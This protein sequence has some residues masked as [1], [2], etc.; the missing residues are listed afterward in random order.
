MSARYPVLIVCTW[1][2]RLAGLLVPRN[3]RA[4]W[5]QDWAAE[6]RHGCADLEHRGYSRSETWSKLLR[7]SIGGFADAADL[8]RSH[9]DLRYILGHPAFCLAVPVALLCIA[10]GSTRGFRHSRQALAGL[11]WH[12]PEELVLLSRSAGVM[13]IEATPAAADF[14][15]WQERFKGGVAG[16]AVDGTVLRVTP[17]FYDVL[18]EVPRVPFDFLGHTIQAVKPLG[19]ESKHI[20]ILAGRSG[21]SCEASTQ[22]IPGDKRERHGDKFPAGART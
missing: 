15:R 5:I 21:R 4:Q 1:A 22:A 6:V 11:P 8:R 10:C 14:I 12:R 13:G 20:G 3:I 18:G 7:F 17:S 19:P 9:F 2:L 16:F